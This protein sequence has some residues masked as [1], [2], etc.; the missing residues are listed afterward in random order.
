MP[1]P[2]YPAQG[3]PRHARAA[4]VSSPMTGHGPEQ[5]APQHVPAEGRER[6]SLQAE[7]ERLQRELAR[8]RSGAP[9]PRAADTLRSFWIA[10]ALCGGSLLFALMALW[11][12]G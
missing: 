8:A 3:G 2:H 7:V 10:V 5:I 1:R 12:R 4:S 9:A 11:R 6:Q